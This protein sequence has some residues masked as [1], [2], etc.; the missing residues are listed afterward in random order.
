MKKLNLTDRRNPDYFYSESIKTL[1]TNIQLSGQSIKTILVTSCYPNEGKSDIALS[2]AQ[3]LG[4][5][6][7]KVLLLDADIRKTAYVGRLEVQEE[8]KGLSQ[9]LSGQAGLQDIIY[10]TNFP[11]MDIIFGGP[12]APNPSGLLSENIFKILI[13]ELKDY[14][15]YILIDTPPIGT[16]I[17]AAVIGRCCDGAVFLIQPGNVRY[18]DAQKAFAQLE[19][20]GCRILG[21]VLNKI[22]TSGDKYYSSY[23]KHYGEYYRRDED[24]SEE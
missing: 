10:N 20:S 4:S 16:V 19:K 22:D 13:K 24:D 9:L 3:E 15:N 2:L 17:D 14:Y 6:G 5:I 21:A 12:S 7:K 11:N 23:Y 18:R 8:V 1:R